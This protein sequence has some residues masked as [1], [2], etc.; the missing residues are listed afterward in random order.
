MTYL[1]SST[2]ASLILLLSAVIYF[3]SQPDSLSVLLLF[4]LLLNPI[5]ILFY[6]MQTLNFTQFSLS[7]SSS[8]D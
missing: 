5:M 2:H 7:L 1:S 6:H 3:L 4:Q 8:M